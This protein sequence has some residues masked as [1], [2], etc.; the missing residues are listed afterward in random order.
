MAFTNKRT[1]TTAIDVTVNS[2]IALVS[3]VSILPFLYILSVSFTDPAT[4]EPFKVILFPTRFSLASY[5]Y[6]LSSGDFLSALKSTFFITS[7]GTV[8][9]LLITFS[10]AYGITK[11]HL[12]LRSF[13]MFFVI[14]ELLFDPGIIPKYILVKNLG[15]INSYWSCIL[16][17][18]TNS[19][20]VIVA[21][22][23]IESIPEEL[24]EASRIDGCSQIGTF[25]KI[26]L[27]LSLASI[28]TLALFFAVSHWNM[29]IKPL[30]YL[31]DP[32]KRTLQVYLKGLLVDGESWGAGVMDLQNIP[33]E[34]LRMCA[35]ILAMLPIL[36][37]Y[38]FV[39]RYFIKGAMIGS[40]KG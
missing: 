39:Q 24:D 27:P 30:M 20:S 29:Y 23:F 10:F 12:P 35:V 11:K 6:V 32:T 7:V 28:A 25:V 5:R 4:Y 37:V 40:V 38:P 14:F 3:L 13:F 15:L 1:K 33:S 9:N 16:P 19:W 22:S 21:K 8:L 2:I 36:L 26:I 34:T 17:A 18:L 31:S